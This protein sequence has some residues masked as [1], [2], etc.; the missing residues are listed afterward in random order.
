MLTSDQEE[1]IQKENLFMSYVSNL[2]YTIASRTPPNFTLSGKKHRRIY[3]ILLTEHDFEVK[4]TQFF[5]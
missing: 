2:Q 1:Q 3:F 4:L 5:L